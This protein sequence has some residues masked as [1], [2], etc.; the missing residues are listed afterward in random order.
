MYVLLHHP[1][2]THTITRVTI[3]STPPL[4][5]EAQAS[6]PALSHAHLGVLLRHVLLGELS[7]L[8]KLRD[9]FL[10]IV[11]VGAIHQ[12][13]GH[14]VQDGL[15]TGLGHRAGRRPLERKPVALGTERLA[16]FF[17]EKKQSTLEG[18]PTLHKKCG[19]KWSPT[20]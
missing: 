1:Q 20:K 8:H 7:Q 3:F 12:G 9:D 2:G 14:R 19:K 5:K 13:G 15:V 10:D 16:G 17:L 11:A 6:V 18:N 4:L